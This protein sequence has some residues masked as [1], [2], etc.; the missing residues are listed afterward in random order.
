MKDSGGMLAQRFVPLLRFQ[1]EGGNAF[2]FVLYVIEPF[3]FFALSRRGIINWHPCR[4]HPNFLPREEP[5]WRL[6]ASGDEVPSCL[7]SMVF[8]Q[9]RNKKVTLLFNFTK[10]F[11]GPQEELYG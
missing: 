11:N 7:A 6:F 2:F 8:I 1:R 3:L 9:Y 10:I 5:E 4:E